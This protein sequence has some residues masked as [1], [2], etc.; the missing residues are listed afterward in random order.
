[1]LASDVRHLVDALEAAQRPP[2]SPEVREEMFRLLYDAS[3]SQFMRSN[4]RHSMV[5]EQRDAILARFS[6]PS[7]PVYDEEKI[8]RLVEQQMRGAGLSDNPAEFD[9][10]IHSWGCEHPDRYGPCGCFQE[11]RNGLV[12]ALVAALRNGELTREGTKR[13]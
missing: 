3:G 12:A 9:S 2:V 4:E 1:M 6:V 13:G 8:A 5:T 7:Q 11:M 10:S